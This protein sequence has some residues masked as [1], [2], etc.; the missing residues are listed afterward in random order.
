MKKIEIKDEKECCGCRNCENI[1]P[2]NAISMKENREGFLYPEVD[3]SRCVD[4]GLCKS[5]CPMLNDVNREKYLSSP[6]SYAAKTNDKEVQ[7][8]SSSGG[9]FGTLANYILTEKGLVVGCEMTQHHIIHHIVVEKE[10]DMHKIMGS[11]YVLSDLGNIFLFIKQ[12]LINNKKVLFCGTP[13]QVS[14][15][16][17]FLK[18]RYDYLYTV[19]VIC[20]GVPSQKAFSKYIEY[21]EDKYGAKLVDYKFRSKKA[22]KW[23]TF[24]ALATFENV[25]SK[26]IIKRINADF[27]PYYWSF[28]NCKNYRKSC[29]SCKFANP[30]RN[31]DLTLGDF[32]GIEKIVSDMIDYNGV[33]VVV[34]NSERGKKLLSCVKENLSLKEVNYD[35]ICQNNGQLTAPSPQPPEREFWYNNIDDK[36][37]FKKIHIKPNFKAYFK[38]L[39]PQNLKF[40]LK[41][42]LY[43]KK[44]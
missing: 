19:D 35:L 20:H 10:V 43:N 33:S 39:F 16:L 29:Y 40:T 34:I 7:L 22:A 13:C 28:L 1:C 37:F 11:K 32:W 21:L 31:A 8:N 26:K 3:K 9:L 36:D 27:D 15:L 14:A 42:V 2:K 44:M 17:L 41:K 4:C 12:Q 18:K 25:H 23:G 24:K 5:V 6:I 38:I 30:E